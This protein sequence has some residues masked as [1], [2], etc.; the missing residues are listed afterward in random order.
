[1]RI[2]FSILFLICLFS[3]SPTKIS[4][5]SKSDF[6]W[7]DFDSKFLL[8]HSFQKSAPKH[9]ANS[10]FNDIEI[11]KSVDGSGYEYYFAD[12]MICR[13]GN[14]DSY[15]RETFDDNYLIF[16]YHISRGAA[17][18]ELL[19]RDRIFVIS[20]SQDLSIYEL[21]LEEPIQLTFHRYFLEEYG[22]RSGLFAID[23]ITENTMVLLDSDLNY[24][25]VPL[26]KV[27]G[28]LIL[29]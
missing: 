4:T 26:K 20:L 12:K 16:S 10:V 13:T 24:K 17:S 28:L 9:N 27:E 1:M 5:P 7:D 29:E 6:S 15:I 19:I 18:P 11:K 8:A 14:S 2:V 3:C 22:K 25:L 23:N 21:E